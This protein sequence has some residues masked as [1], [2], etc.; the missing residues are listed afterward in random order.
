MVDT[1]LSNDEVIQQKLEDAIQ[2]LSDLG[3]P[4]EQQN[5][6]SALCLL[7]LLDVTPEKSW[8]DAQ[9]RKMGI[10]PIMDWSEKYYKKGY[11]ANTR[12][13]FR[14]SSMHQ[15]VEAAIALENPDKPD[16]A[17][18]SPKFCYQIEPHVLNLVISFGTDNYKHKLDEYVSERKS[19]IETYERARAMHLVP[20]NLPDGQVINLSAGEHSILI[21]DIIESFAPRFIQ[22]GIPLYAGDTGDKHGLFNQEYLKKLNVILDGHG[23]L[24]DVVIHDPNRD[25]LF[26]IESVT[27]TGPVDH[28]RYLELKRLFKDCSAGLVFVS[29]FPDR[30]MYARFS[31]AI[32]W[33]TEVWIAEHPTHMI[34]LN[35]TRFMGPYTDD[36]LNKEE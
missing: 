26:L 16:R 7:A 12:E 11:A 5:Q 1:Q 22:G 23:K 19:L 20:L 34:H 14:K 8:S 18:N 31:S 25:W 15:F 30:K 27:S 28:K 13:N 4:K 17:K 10:T 24:P 33:E 2:I 21:K 9:E 32:A 36:E 6:I 35:G 3:M 29:A